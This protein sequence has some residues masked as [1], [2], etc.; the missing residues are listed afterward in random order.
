MGQL[1]EV[2][3]GVGVEV[4]GNV[5]TKGRGRRKGEIARKPSDKGEIARKIATNVK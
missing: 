5:L 3:I 1:F 4:V 2:L